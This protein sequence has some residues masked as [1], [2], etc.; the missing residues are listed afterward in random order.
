MTL[1]FCYMNCGTCLIEISKHQSNWRYWHWL[2]WAKRWQIRHFDNKHV[3]LTLTIKIHKLT[4]K[5]A[6]SCHNLLWKSIFIHKLTSVIL[7]LVSCHWKKV[8]NMLFWQK[9]KI[10]LDFNRILRHLSH[11]TVHI[12]LVHNI[13]NDGHL[14]LNKNWHCD[15]FCCLGHKSTVF[16]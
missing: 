4:S 13:D 6:M 5:S 3:T 16:T 7:K 14:T 12:L 9:L 11:L 2:L 1:T 8:V 10:L 15:I